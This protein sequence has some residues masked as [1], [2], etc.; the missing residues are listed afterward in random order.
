MQKEEFMKTLENGSEI[1][2]LD[3]READELRDGESIQGAMHMPMGKIFTEIAKDNLPKNKHIL[4]FCRKGGRA[5][6]VVA[7]LQKRGFN[8]D[9]LD[10][11]LNG[12][13]TV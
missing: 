1:L 3:I 7:E 12:L 9:G 10:G 8:I 4:V 2:L 13:R 5:G 11:G 6:I